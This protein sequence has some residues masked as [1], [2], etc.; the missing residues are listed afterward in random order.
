MLEK[1]GPRGSD[2]QTKAIPMNRELAS[3]TKYREAS[4]KRFVAK[5]YQQQS[6]DEQQEH[7][8]RLCRGEKLRVSLALE[9]YSEFRAHR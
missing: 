7:Y 9:A 8:T 1:R 6:D 4:N 3:K 2:W 5:L